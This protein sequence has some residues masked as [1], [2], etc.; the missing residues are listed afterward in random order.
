MCILYLFELKLNKKI[1]I[2]LEAPINTYTCTNFN[3]EFVGLQMMP[4]R[5]V[6][7]SVLTNNYTDYLM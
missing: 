4:G 1:E 7:L 2:K 3:L 6:S 5:G